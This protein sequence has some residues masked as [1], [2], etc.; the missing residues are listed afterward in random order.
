[1]P[2]F[3]TILIALVLT[4]LAGLSTGVG[5]LISFFTRSTDTRLLAGALG[6]SA[7]VMVYISFMELM[8]QAVESL[9]AIYSDR[10]ATSIMLAAF[11]GGIGLIAAIDYLVPE[12]ENPHETHTMNELERPDSH[13]KLKRTGTMLALAIGIHNFPEGMATFISCLDGLEVALPI[14][15]AIAIHNIPEGI[16]VSVPIYHSTGNRRKALRYS[17][18]SGLAEPAG[19]LVGMAFLLPFWSPM[20]NAICLASV[21][22]IMVYIAFDELLPSAESFGHHHLSL[23]GVIVGMAIMALTILVL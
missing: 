16:A 3:S 11:F 13:H 20:V 14:M 18:I 6:L 21:A 5:A 10:V 12:D 1:M 23:L 9:E 2:E 17:L 15:V 7:G 22:G 8:P 4:A 19:A